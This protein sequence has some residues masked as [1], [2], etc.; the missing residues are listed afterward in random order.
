MVFILGISGSPRKGSTTRTLVNTM[1]AACKKH[2]AETELLDLAET[3]LPFFDNR[4]SEDYGAEHKRVQ[5]LLAKADGF[6][7]GSP[8][9]HGS[10]SGMLKNFLDLSDYER[11]L[12]GKP[13]AFCVVGGGSRGKSA[14]D[15]FLIV[16]RALRVWAVP[17]VVG[18]N[19]E[20]YDK[21]WKIASPKVI[22]RIEGATHDL[23]RAA[24]ALKK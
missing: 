1:L 13:A 7:I 6:V 3:S 20:D 19:K 10:I 21:D 14:L 8:E 9:Y 18:T 15:H 17:H 4:D 2:G 22:Q 12:S 11:V 5:D 16:A 23:V 24:K